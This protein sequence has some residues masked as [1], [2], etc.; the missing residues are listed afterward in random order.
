[1]AGTIQ[2]V[3]DLQDTQFKS[4]LNKIICKVTK[5]CSSIILEKHNNGMN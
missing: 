5:H 2:L 1:M 3:N 4:I